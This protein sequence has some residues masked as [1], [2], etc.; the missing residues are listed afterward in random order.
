VKEKKRERNEMKGRFGR[1]KVCERKNHL[2]ANKIL[3][4][5]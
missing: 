3:D 2:D 4:R 1:S 5:D